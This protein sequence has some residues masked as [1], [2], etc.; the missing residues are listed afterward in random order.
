MTILSLQ[1]WS[2]LSLQSLSDSKDYA[3]LES[4]VLLLKCLKIM[5]NA[6]F[7]S[8]DNQVISIPTLLFSRLPFRILE[9]LDVQFCIGSV[10][11]SLASNERKIRWSELPKVFHKANLKRDQDSLRYYCLLYFHIKKLLP[12]MFFVFL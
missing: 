9:V 10:S 5:E 4:L 11:E 7:L 8:M 6:T 1:G 12:L 2:E 3:A